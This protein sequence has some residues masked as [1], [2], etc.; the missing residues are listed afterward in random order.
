MSAPVKA[1]WLS[2]RPPQD[3]GVKDGRLAPCPGSPNC[4]NS[5]SADKARIAPLAYLDPAQSAWARLA[6]ALTELPRIR[7]V[8][9]TDRYL[10]AEATSRVFGFVD[11]LEFMLDRDANVIHVR[12]A[13]RVG[14]SDL[15]VNRDRIERLR[16]LFSDPGSKP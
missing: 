10:R 14:Y 4:V 8:E 6:E 3:L 1:G 5:Q 12:S 11:D 16:A 13:S 2:G 7:I 15:G 9:R